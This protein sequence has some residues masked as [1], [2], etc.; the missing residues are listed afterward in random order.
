VSPRLHDAAQR[1]DGQLWQQHDGAVGMHEE[2]DP[3]ARFQPR[4]SRTAFGMVAWPLLVMADSMSVP[5]IPQ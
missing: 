1:G 3:I 5:Y 4:C 2:L